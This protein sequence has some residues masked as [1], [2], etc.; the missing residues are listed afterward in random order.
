M[1]LRFL[2]CL[3]L[4]SASMGLAGNLYRWVDGEGNVHYSDQPPPP[5]VKEVQEKTLGVSVIE[6]SQPYGLRQAVKN[7]PVTLFVSDCGAGCTRAREL[8]NKRGV[9]FTEK[10]PNQP[11]NAD[12]L[13]K[14]VG[15]L[16]VP[17]LV[18]GNTQPLRGF[19]ESSWNNALNFAGYPSAPV[20]G[21]PSGGRTSGPQ[22]SAAPAPAPTPESKP[23]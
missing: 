16:V 21:A 4:F 6:G 5:S 2:F 7:F 23:Y 1:K 19:E 11:E 18:V 15:D 13:K 14:I 9:P 3:L 10:N 8:L 17:V 12:E 22:P 20:P